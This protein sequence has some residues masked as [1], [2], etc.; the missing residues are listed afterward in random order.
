MLLPYTWVSF[1][2]FVH[3]SK[4]LKHSFDH[5]YLVMVPVWFLLVDTFLVRK[6]GQMYF[7]SILVYGSMLKV[8]Y[9]ELLN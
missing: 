7:V 9:E 5:V 3:F 8:E 2:F 1:G 6:F 4:G